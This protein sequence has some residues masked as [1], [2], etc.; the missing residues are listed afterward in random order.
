MASRMF[1]SVSH[2]ELPV[3]TQPGKSGECAENP[4]S[5]SSIII[6]IFHDFNPACLSM[7]LTVPD[8]RSFGLVLLLVQASQGACT[9]GDYPLFE[10][11]SNRLFR[12]ALSLP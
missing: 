3:D 1:F 2:V 12:H 6:K 10:L 9:V 4:D 7:L 11:V 8:Q 5:V